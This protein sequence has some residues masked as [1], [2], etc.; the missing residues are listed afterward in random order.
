[1]NPSETTAG[2]LTH[3]FYYLAANPSKQTLL[4]SELSTLPKSSA[5]V[6][7]KALQDAPF[8]NSVINETLRLWPPVLSGMQ[9][10]TP[11]EGIT[12]GKTFIPGNVTVYSPG[13]TVQ[14]CKFVPQHLLVSY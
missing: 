4:R 2:T 12:V 8:L 7:F 11:P 10:L 5:E 9:Y 1:V 13:Y 6:D 3:L 14:R